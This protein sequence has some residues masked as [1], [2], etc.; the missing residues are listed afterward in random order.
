MRLTITD[1]APN[2]AELRADL[3]A[4]GHDYLTRARANAAINNAYFELANLYDWPFLEYIDTVST[5]LELRG[6]RKVI[7]VNN[8][9]T[10]APVTYI[11]HSVIAR[12][13]QR[14]DQ[15]GTASYY[16]LMGDILWLHPDEPADFDVHYVGTVSQLVDD[17]DQ[18]HIPRK[19][20]Q[21]LVDGANLWALKEDNNYEAIAALRQ[22]WDR[23][24][25]QMVTS[26]FRRHSNPDFIVVTQASDDWAC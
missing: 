8:T 7:S 3:I 12:S 21:T 26:E 2:L 1:D 18:V 6:V 25:Q 24:V 23:G 11:D 22:E 10:H 17:T 4:R 9:L 15:I 13:G 14:L 16:S 19:Y 20:K 5:P